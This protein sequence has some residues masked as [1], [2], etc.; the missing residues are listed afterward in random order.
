M[1]A[2]HRGQSSIG[3]FSQNLA[4]MLRHVA[5]PDMHVSAMKNGNEEWIVSVRPKGLGI[6]VQH[7]ETSCN[8]PKRLH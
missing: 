7:F 5:V 6:D 2:D 1:P 8:I 3:T 4:E